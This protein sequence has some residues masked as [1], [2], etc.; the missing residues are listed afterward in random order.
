MWTR[1]EDDRI[2]Q[3]LRSLLADGWQLSAVFQALHT[4]DG[5]GKLHL[6]HSVERITGIRPIEAKKV[7][8][9]ACSSESIK[10]E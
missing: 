9:L 8:T 10:H 2:D 6:C 4:L 7:V 5:I 3:R 1:I